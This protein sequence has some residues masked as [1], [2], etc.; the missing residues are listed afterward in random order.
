MPVPLI[1][2]SVGVTV[3][4]YETGHSIDDRDGGLAAPADEN[5]VFDLVAIKRSI[6]RLK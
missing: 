6:A 3:T 2:E 5:A 4:R 1:T